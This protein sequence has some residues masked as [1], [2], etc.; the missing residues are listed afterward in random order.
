MATSLKNENSIVYAVNEIVE[1][2]IDYYQNLILGQQVY[3]TVLYT[4]LFKN[5]TQNAKQCAKFVR[6]IP[7]E[8]F[9]FQAVIN[10]HKT[11]QR[12]NVALFN[13]SELC[14]FVLLPVCLHL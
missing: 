7:K 3:S 9:T 4:Y 5:I 8:D 13:L 10:D 2:S 6:G 11:P 1:D 12:E 14:S